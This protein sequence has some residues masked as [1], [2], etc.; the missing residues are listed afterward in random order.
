MISEGKTREDFEELHARFELAKER[1]RRQKNATVPKPFRMAVEQLKEEGRES[2]E[3]AVLRDIRRDNLVLPER[4]WPFLSTRAPVA[5]T[6]PPT[7]GADPP[8]VT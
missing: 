2:K 8:Q 7:E 3:E 1:A 5:P 4:R 6:P